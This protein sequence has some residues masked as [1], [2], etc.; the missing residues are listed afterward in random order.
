MKDQTEIILLGR[1][2]SALNSLAMQLK[3]LQCQPVLIAD[4]TKAK[5][6]LRSHQAGLVMIAMEGVDEPLDLLKELTFL[7]RGLPLLAIATRGSVHEA[8]QTIDA[9]AADYLLLPVDNEVLSAQIK[10]YNNQFFDPELGRGRR[11][12]TADPAMLK[13][14]GQVRRVSNSNATVLIQ[15]ESGTGKELMARYVHQV[16]DRANG[17]FVA[18]NCAA[19]P[20]NLL[21][22]EL[23]GHIKGAFT[24]A[25]SDRKGKFLQANGGTIFLDEISEMTLN[26]QA[27][28]LRVLQEKEVDP[29]GG[30]HP[31]ALDVRVIASTNRDLKEYAADGLFREDLYYRLNVFPVFITPL[32]QRP[33]DVVLLADLFRQRFIKELGRND[34]PFDAAAMDALVR[35]RWPGNIRE[36]ENV[37]Q[38]ALLIAEDDAVSSHD[39][40][41][42]VSGSAAP[43]PSMTRDAD[44]MGMALDGDHIHMPVGTTVREMEEILIRRT[45]D[46]VDGNRTRAAEIL[47]ISIR[48]LRNKLNE[49]AGRIP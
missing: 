8:K 5:T 21:E 40:M 28:L 31:I 44:E 9:G 16:S 23:F 42:E 26:L 6:Y 1:S 41:I 39:L 12:V 7:F 32:R 17:P 4:V 2:D 47:G 30:K 43:S 3:S 46:E 48:T 45:L 20:E 29:V 35:Y 18:I 11:L 24:G 33:K 14:L 37:V 49:Y 27:K 15:G 19:L 25:T 22:S 10:R 38:R 36:L 13:L 34:I